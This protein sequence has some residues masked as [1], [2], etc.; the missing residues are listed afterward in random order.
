MDW[1]K[2]QIKHNN[3][4]SGLRHIE[5]IAYKQD[6]EGSSAFD[7]LNDVGDAEEIG[8]RLGIDFTM[9]DYLAEDVLRAIQQV[10][11]Y[12]KRSIDDPCPIRS[13]FI[14]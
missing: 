6:S 2:G 11:H 7:E 1:L 4:L 13:Y 5:V 3:S 14:L 8:A 9:K 12:S 10:L